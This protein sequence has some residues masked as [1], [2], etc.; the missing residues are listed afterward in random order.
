MF[1]FVYF[2]V[3]WHFTPLS[4]WRGVGGEAGSGGGTVV[5]GKASCGVRPVGVEVCKL[6][7]AVFL[8][9]LFCL[10]GCNDNRAM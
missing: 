6:A 2:V 1:L 9:K 4:P 10:L 3:A 7:V 5:G 8:F